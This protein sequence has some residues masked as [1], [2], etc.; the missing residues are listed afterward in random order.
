LRE[1]RT[2]SR[3][4]LAWAEEA[5]NAQIVAA[6]TK[7]VPNRTIIF[8]PLGRV[9]FDEPLCWPVEARPILAYYRAAGIA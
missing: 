2:A 9:P 7:R 8:P 3:E 4:L 6:Q 5:A 1:V